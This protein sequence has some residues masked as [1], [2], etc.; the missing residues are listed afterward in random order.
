M[1]ATGVM[2]MVLLMMT[3]VFFIDPVEPEL[4]LG[5]GWPDTLWPVF[6][7]VCVF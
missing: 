1:F 6:F 7:G 3:V 2:Y 4:R 5:E